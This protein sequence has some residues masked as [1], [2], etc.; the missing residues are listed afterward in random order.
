MKSKSNADE[1][2]KLG[3][4]LWEEYLTG[5]R[6]FLDAVRFPAYFLDG[7]TRSS[8]SGFRDALPDIHWLF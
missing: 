2:N 6:P 4:H 7:L 1:A 3:V 8:E 5:E